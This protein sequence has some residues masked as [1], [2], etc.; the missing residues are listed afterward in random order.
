MAQSLLILATD[1]TD[2]PTS[3]EV[4][5]SVESVEKLHDCRVQH[6]Q[7]SLDYPYSESRQF[8]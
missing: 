2:N 7:Q 5:S 1:S 4:G 6:K 3:I 8:R